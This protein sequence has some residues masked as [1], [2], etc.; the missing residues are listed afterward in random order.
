MTTTQMNRLARNRDSQRLALREHCLA[1]VTG[2]DYR[3]PGAIM[4][5]NSPKGGYFTKGVKS[6]PCFTVR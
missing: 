2:Q 1:E 3:K 5:D 4:R 6:G